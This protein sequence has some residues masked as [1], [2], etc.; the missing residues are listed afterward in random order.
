MISMIVNET[1]F[2]FLSEKLGNAYGRYT[3]LSNPDSWLKTRSM[4]FEST[5]IK[6]LKNQI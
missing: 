4:G 1:E 6:P 2:T 3:T 5:D